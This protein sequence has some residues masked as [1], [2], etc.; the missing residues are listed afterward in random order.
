MPRATVDPRAKAMTE[1]QLSVA[2]VACAE[3]LGWLVYFSPDWMKRIIFKRAKANE[4]RGGYR[5]PKAGLPD[6]I[7]VRDGRLVYAELKSHAGSLADKQIEWLTE[8]RTVP[9][10]EVYTWKPM[11]WLNGD[12]EAVF[13]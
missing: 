4:W 13:R 8:L 10:I 2:V 11:D 3:Q 1:E 12:I 5:W 7:A 6:V 9:G